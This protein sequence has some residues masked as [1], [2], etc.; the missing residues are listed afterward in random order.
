MPPSLGAVTF[1]TD[2]ADQAVVLPVVAV[3]ALVLAVQGWMRGALAWL[4]AVTATFG[5]VLLLKL[6][7]G[8]CLPVFGPLRISSPSGHAAAA[9]ILCGGFATLRSARPWVAVAA[10][11]AGGAV[12]GATRVVLGAHSLPEVSIGALAGTLGAGLLAF[13]SGPAPVA[14]RRW[15]VLA[16]A[17]VVAAALHGTRLPAER[18]IN[19]VSTV[20]AR[21]VPACVATPLPQE[22]ISD[23]VRPP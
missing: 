14:L 20:L 7:F 13:L 11:F 9:A 17:L 19:Q 15:L 23:R 1:L 4:V 3:V 2:L 6:V 10:A 16:A 8:G 22:G 21:F 18:V 5:V 12:I